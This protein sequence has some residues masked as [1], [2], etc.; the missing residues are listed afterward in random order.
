MHPKWFGTITWKKIKIYY[1]PESFLQLFNFFSI[2]LLKLFLENLRVL[3]FSDLNSCFK[4]SFPLDQ[5]INQKI[6]KFVDYQLRNSGK[7][8]RV[9]NGNSKIWKFR[10]AKDPDPEIYLKVGCGCKKL[11]RFQIR[12]QPFIIFL[13]FQ[14]I[15]TL[16]GP[17][18][19]EHKKFFF[20]KSLI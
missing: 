6:W 4:A 19:V 13:Q 2:F 12:I 16:N 1:L 10:G 7:C 11:F 3:T 20:G 18:V 14:Q 5:G 9:N 15:F 8:K 17:Y